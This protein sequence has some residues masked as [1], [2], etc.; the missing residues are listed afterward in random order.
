MFDLRPRSV[1]G[2]ANVVG[3]IERGRGLQQAPFAGD[4]LGTIHILKTVPP[5][6]EAQDKIT[7]AKA[8]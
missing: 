1:S 6:G 5:S 8:K 2:R 4:T 3:R 7:N